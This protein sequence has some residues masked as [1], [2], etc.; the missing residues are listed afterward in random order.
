MVPASDL[1]RSRPFALAARQAGVA[2][3][4]R[5]GVYVLTG[6]QHTARAAAEALAKELGLALLRIDLAQVAGQYIG[7]TEKNLSCLLAGANAATTV[8]FF[9]EAD[10]LF[11]KRTGVRDAHDRYANQE[12]SY[13][14]QR[15]EAW[16]GVVA[17]GLRASGLQVRFARK[18]PV[19]VRWP[20]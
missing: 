13:L 12:V 11:G 10:A 8:L 16:P 1:R 3:G 9:D 7:E 15:I 20:P 14:L 19:H 2:A 18:R 5:D 4:S 17:I 6:V